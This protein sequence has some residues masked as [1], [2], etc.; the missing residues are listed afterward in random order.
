[1]IDK[2]ASAVRVSIGEHDW[3]EDGDRHHGLEIKLARTAPGDQM[4]VIALGPDETATAAAA[5]RSRRVLT[6]L[7]RHQAIE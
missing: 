3:K 5:W 7:T 6:P 1:M 2:A 4:F